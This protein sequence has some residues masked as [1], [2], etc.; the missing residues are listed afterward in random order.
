MIVA[1]GRAMWMS[2]SM[3]FFRYD[4]YVQPIP[5]EIADY[6][7][8]DFSVLNARKTSAVHMAQ[9]GEVWWYY[10]SSNATECDRIVVY[11]YNEN[12]WSLHH[13]LQRNCGAGAGATSYVWMA[14]SSGY[15]YEHEVPGLTTRGSLVPYLESGP[16]EIGA[17][18]VVMAVDG[19]I[20]D[21]K[22][23]GDVTISIYGSF[24]PDED[25]TLYGPFTLASPTYF[26][27]KARQVRV[28]YVEAVADDWRVGTVRLSAKPSSRR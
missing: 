11:N 5:C 6:V 20:P 23:L 12:H 28:R 16:I 1:D 19:V 25:E 18:D 17:G 14:D 2:N 27:M 8:G 24:Y 3:Q 26:R 7:F 10:C 22:T 13:T 4:G 9:Y 21:D 15:L